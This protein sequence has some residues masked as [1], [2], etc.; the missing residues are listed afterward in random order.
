MPFDT[1]PIPP[2]NRVDGGPGVGTITIGNHAPDHNMASNLFSDIVFYLVTTVRPALTQIATR[3]DTTTN[4]V[5]AL[6][7]AG[8]L[9]EC[10]NAAATGV[11]LPANSTTAIPVNT[12]FE[13]CQV[14]AGQVTITPA[15]GVTLHFHSPTNASTAHTGAPWSTVGLRKRATDEWVAT[16]DLV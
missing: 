2:N 13:V 5:V 11:T 10:N 15:I 9:I 1:D 14:G 7:D 12:V 6:S 8:G 4:P 3:V 16:G